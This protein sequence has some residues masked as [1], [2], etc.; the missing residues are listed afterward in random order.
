MQFETARRFYSIKK[1]ASKSLPD[2]FFDPPKAVSDL[3]CLAH[4]QK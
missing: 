3:K 1:G 2:R 4:E